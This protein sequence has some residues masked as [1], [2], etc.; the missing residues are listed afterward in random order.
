M[1]YRRDFAE[2]GGESEA[3]QLQEEI[4]SDK[5]HFVHDLSHT[6]RWKLVWRLLRIGDRDTAYIW[7]KEHCGPHFRPEIT[8]REIARA[9]EEM[10]EDETPTNSVATESFMD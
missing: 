2:H 9:L 5:K 10:G 7:I 1:G 3:Q 6:E 4:E 8:E